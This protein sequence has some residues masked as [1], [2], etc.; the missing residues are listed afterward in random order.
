MS[1][2]KIFSNFKTYAF[3]C[4]AK[5]IIVGWGLAFKH[6][7][8]PGHGAVARN[9]VPVLRD[10]SDQEQFERQDLD[11]AQGQDSR[12]AGSSTGKSAQ[13]ET[14]EMI[15]KEL[16]RL[17]TFKLQANTDS[18]SESDFESERDVFKNCQRNYYRGPSCA[19]ESQAN[20]LLPAL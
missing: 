11:L 3:K 15:Y 2:P 20:L 17:M 4:H 5:D 18:D 7:I 1:G 8:G 19:A 13:L 16:A 6:V 14:D 9:A 12:A 10:A